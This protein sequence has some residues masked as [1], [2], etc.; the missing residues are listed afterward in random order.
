LLNRLEFAED[1][2][3]RW[4]DSGGGMHML[5]A[6]LYHAMLEDGFT[7]SGGNYSEW[8][9]SALQRGL[10]D[11]ASVRSRATTIVGPE[12]VAQWDEIRGN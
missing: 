8:L 3:E 11:P 6:S 12:T 9:K 1:P 2:G 10:L 4:R 7:E 5:A